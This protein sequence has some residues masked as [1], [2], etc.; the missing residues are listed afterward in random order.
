MI[1]AMAINDLQKAVKFIVTT[2]AIAVPLYFLFTFTTFLHEIAA[3]GAQFFL[4]LL[5]K[6]ASLV[7]TGSPLFPHLLIPGGD[8]EISDLCSGAL[9]LALLIGFISASADRSVNYRIK[10]IVVGVVFFLLF[11]AARIAFTINSF[12]TAAFVP[13]HDVLFRLTLIIGLVT[14]YAV[15]YYWR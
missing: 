2:A 11:N 10:G 5:G 1:R 7:F 8:I 4:T 9:E 6:S 12:G 3:R 13:L 14:F 15:W